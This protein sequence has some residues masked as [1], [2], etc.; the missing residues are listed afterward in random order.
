M[1]LFVS[2][3]PT[4]IDHVD[5]FFELATLSN[6]DVVYDLGSGDGR[7]LFMAL[8]KGAGRAVGIELNPDL[9][10]EASETAKRKSLQ[11]R[12]IFLNADFMDVSLE[13]ASVVLCYLTPYASAALKVKLESELK[14]GSRVVVEMFPVP[15]WKPTKQ[16][17]REGKQFYLYNMP[18][19][20]SKESETRDALI[21]YLNYHSTP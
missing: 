13:D 3:I 21:D 9:V 5:A 2:F 7:L 18:P 17:N 1:P 6:S 19:E 12:I 4:Q 20:I 16:I 11:D 8:E 14:L 10:R 15:A